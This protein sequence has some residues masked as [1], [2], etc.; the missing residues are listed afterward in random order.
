MVIEKG[1]IDEM[2]EDL[3]CYFNNVLE[4]NDLSY[5]SIIDEIKEACPKTKL[6]LIAPFV[7]EGMIIGLIGA[8][9]PLWIIRFLYDYALK[10]LTER[11]AILMCGVGF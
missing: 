4:D 8:A 7:L 5:S 9:I 2:I 11:F 1:N 3:L 6:V 10:Y